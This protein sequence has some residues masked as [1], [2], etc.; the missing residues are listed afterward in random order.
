MLHYVFL[1][2]HEKKKKIN[3][4]KAAAVRNAIEFLLVLEWLEEQSAQQDRLD[5]HQQLNGVSAALKTLAMRQQLAEWHQSI[6]KIASHVFD[7]RMK[8]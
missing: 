3:R 1:L 6:G 4:E 5:P 2:P 8:A 7:R